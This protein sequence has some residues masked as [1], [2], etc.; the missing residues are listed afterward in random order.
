MRQ[1]TLWAKKAMETASGCAP[2]QCTLLKQSS[3]RGAVHIMGREGSPLW[4]L[5]GDA[6]GGQ[7]SH[8]SMCHPVD[9]AKGSTV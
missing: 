7:T 6:K 2:G 9:T 3:G 4:S 5:S 8:C 1:C